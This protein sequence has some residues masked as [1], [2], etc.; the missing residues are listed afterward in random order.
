MWHNINT[1]SIGI[2]VR[3]AYAEVVNSFDNEIAKIA[4]KKKKKNSQN[5]LKIKEKNLF[6]KLY[7]NRCRKYNLDVIL[8]T[9]VSIKIKDF[10][11]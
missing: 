5:I 1:H 4:S 11:S 7:V 2:F 8:D 10:E 6:K 3:I 9:L